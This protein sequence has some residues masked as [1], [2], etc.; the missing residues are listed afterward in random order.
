MYNT[1]HV[2]DMGGMFTILSKKEM[3]K[4]IPRWILFEAF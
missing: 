4:N 1:A 3:T 2:W